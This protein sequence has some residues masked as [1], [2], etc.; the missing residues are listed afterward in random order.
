MQLLLL[1]LSYHHF[2]TFTPFARLIPTQW[3]TKYA[4]AKTT[5]STK[6][7][8]TWANKLGTWILQ[9]GYELWLQR[10]NQIHDKERRR[11]TVDHIL[12]QK[13]RQ[14]YVLQEEINY[15]DRDIFSIPEED[16]LKLPHQ[17]MTWITRQ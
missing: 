15:H 7:T 5:V 3:T 2:Q 10:N 13:I 17:K 1:R 8:Q 4:T 12:N 6:T 9:Q 14:L 11:S 16:R